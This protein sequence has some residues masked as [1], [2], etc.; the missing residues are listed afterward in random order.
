M[1]LTFAFFFLGLLILVVGAEGLVRGSSALALRL[2]VTPLDVAQ[3]LHPGL[4]ERQKTLEG[5]D[6]RSFG[7]EL[8]RYVRDAS[9]A[10]I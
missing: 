1:V 2:G 3:R 8:V 9:R 10:L 6:P 7:Y 4:T 5:T